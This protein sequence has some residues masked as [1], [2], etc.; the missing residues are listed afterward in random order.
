MLD[1]TCSFGVLGRTGRGLTE[2]QNVDPLQ[3]EM[4]VGALSGALCAGGGFCAGAKDVVEHQRIMAASYCF[5]A[6]L[7]AMMAVTASETIN[8]LQSSPEMLAQ[9]RENIKAMR[10]QLD[11]RSDWVNCISAPENP[12]ML[13]TIKPAVVDS[14]KLSTD[15]QQK[16]L[17]DCVEEALA[18][19]VLITRLK[20]A[21]IYQALGAKTEDLPFRPALKVI[22][23][24]GLSKKDTEKA[25]VMIRHAITKVLS[26]KA[27]AKGGIAAAA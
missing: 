17:Q 2:A 13:L 9:C 4:I 22:I 15:D 11:P 23:T 20:L 10:A 25:G 1:E 6:A 18:N 21:P 7:P 24:T 27:N 14:R 8:L 26:R 3:V 12:V 16:L 5:S 19:G